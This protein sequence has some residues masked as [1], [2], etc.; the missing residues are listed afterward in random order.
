MSTTPAVSDDLFREFLTQPLT[1]AA[2]AFADAYIA[3]QTAKIRARL[4][5]RELAKR[6]GQSLEEMTVPQILTH[7]RQH[8]CCQNVL[9]AT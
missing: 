2:E 7:H 6:A 4:S 9:E 8:R 3:E 5:E 1:D